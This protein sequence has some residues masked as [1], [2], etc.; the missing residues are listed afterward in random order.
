MNEPSLIVS[1][2]D[3]APRNFQR[4]RQQLEELA[5][6]GVTRVSLLAVP[7][8]HGEK[9]LDEDPA[10]CQWLLD[11][12]S[13]GHEIVLHGWKHESSRFE[14]RG[15]RFNP[16][17]NWFFE[18]LYTTG[19]AEFL[20]LDFT[21]ARNRIQSG[22]EMLRKLRFRI[23]GFISPAWLMN[24]DVERA[25]RDLG[26]DYTNTLSHLIHLPSGKRLAARSCVWSTR[27]EWR[28]ACSLAWNAFLFRRLGKVDPLRISLHPA[29]LEYPAIWRQIK[30][31]IGG[32]L[33]T[34]RPTTYAEWI[35]NHA[36][37]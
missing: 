36:K 25:S 11:C 30:G 5:G 29:D 20:N 32:A 22:L 3:V 21:E 13:K 26:L 16:W 27:A 31:L 28:R 2:H 15:S 33:Q 6:W 19:E 4:V 1:L 9:R 10:L 18:N 34:R 35:K 8:F 14:V 24:T 17:E 23:T 12:Q 7:H 37:N